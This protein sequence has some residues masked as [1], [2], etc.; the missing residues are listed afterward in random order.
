[1]KRL[2]TEPEQPFRED[3]P[4]TFPEILLEA[5]Q[6]GRPDHDQAAQ[7]IEYLGLRFQIGRVLIEERVQ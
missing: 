4:M 2:Q 1:M 3:L 7:L 5:H 6:D